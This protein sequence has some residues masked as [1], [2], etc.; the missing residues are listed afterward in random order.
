M[1]RRR[2]EV[3]GS[4]R[5][6]CCHR[7]HALD[8]FRAR[9]GGARGGDQR[10][11]GPG[12]RPRPPA[13]A[14]PGRRRS[15]FGPGSCGVIEDARS[16]HRRMRPSF[17]GEEMSERENDLAH[18][19]SRLRIRKNVERFAEPGQLSSTF[20]ANR[21]LPRRARQ[22]GFDL[23]AARTRR[24]SHARTLRSIVQAR[25]VP[26]RLRAMRE[27]L[28]AVKKL[29]RK[30]DTRRTRPSGRRREHNRKS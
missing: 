24:T 26:R 4:V 19:G 25:R 20:P 29:L 12:Y 21:P 9:G 15:T 2:H 10:P 17:Q 30:P 11:H 16:P 6:M 13:V 5:L 18:E 28:R 1:A 27:S 8:E 23:P 7:A 3:P 14:P 22:E